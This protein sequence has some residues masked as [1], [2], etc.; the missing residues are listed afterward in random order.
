VD[1]LN[2]WLALAA[3]VGVIA[4][5]IFL[6]YEIRVNTDA[7]RS[8]N[9]AAYNDVSAAWGAFTAEHAADLASITQKPDLT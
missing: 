3:N 2:Q 1:R 5:I 9:Y 6:V 4:G 7:V 8:A